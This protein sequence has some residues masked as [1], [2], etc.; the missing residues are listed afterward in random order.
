MVAGTHLICLFAATALFGGPCAA[1]GSDKPT[2]P[3]TSEQDAPLQPLAFIPP[4]EGAPEARAGAGTRG[5]LQ[6]GGLITLIVP[7]GGGLTTLEKP[8]LVWHLS[9]D[10]DGTIIVELEELSAGGLHVARSLDGRF[11]SGFHALDLGRSNVTLS[12]GHIY[13]WSVRAV[14]TASGKVVEDAASFVERSEQGLAPSGDPESALRAAARAGLW[15]DALVPVF[16]LTLSGQARLEDPE[17]FAALA[18][19]GKLPRS[20]LSFD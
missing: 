11:R 13:R 6:V 20:V 2:P 14:E 18:I 5:A 4:K 7:Q 1:E 12:P 10:F 17:A 8:P 19:S 3:Q 16:S 15:F 9:A